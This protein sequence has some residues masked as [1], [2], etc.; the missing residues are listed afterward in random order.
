[1]PVECCTC[2]DIF[3]NN[4]IQLYIYRGCF[5]ISCRTQTFIGGI[6]EVMEIEN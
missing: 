2:I 5:K 6:V 1:M 3:N 4:I